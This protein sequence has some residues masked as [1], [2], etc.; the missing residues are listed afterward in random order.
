MIPL[1]SR[2]NLFILAVLLPL[3]V[4]SQ[5]LRQSFSLNWKEKEWVHP[6]DPSLKMI[7]FESAVHSPLRDYAPV[8][9]KVIDLPAGTT[10]CKVTVENLLLE[11][12][13]DEGLPL[14]VA[15]NVPADSVELTWNIGIARGQYQLDVEILPLLRAADGKLSRIVRFDLVIEPLGS[16]PQLKMAGFV[17]ESVLS[18]GNWYKLRIKKSGVCKVTY[19]DMQSMGIDMSTVTPSRIRLFGKPGGMLPEN[20]SFFRYDDLPE[21]AIQV[22][23]AAEG[24]FA[25]GDYFLFYAGSPD[26]TIFNTT[27][28]RFEHRQ[29][30]YSE[31]TYYFLNVDGGD[32]KRISVQ[33]QSA[34]APQHACSTFIDFSWYEKDIY[35]LIKSGK[36]WIGDRLDFNNPLFNLPEISFQ[37][38]ETSRQAW[39]RYRLVS[40]ASASSNFSI[41]ANTTNLTSKN[42]AAYTVDTF[43]QE[44]VETKTFAPVEGSQQVSVR[45]NTPNSTALGYIDWIELSVPRKMIFTGGQMWFADPVTAVAGAVTEF[46]LASAPQQVKIWEV[47]SPVN[48]SLVETSRVAD[49]LKF[50][51]A[52]DTLRRFVAWDGSSFLSAEFVEK[53]ENQNLHGI[54]AAEMLIVTHPDFL[55]QAERLANHHRMVDGM[56]VVVATN[57]QIY[58]EFSSGAPD[59]SAI[60]DFARML[61][62]VEGTGKLRYL[63][64][65]GDGSYDYKEHLPN[66]TNYVLAF[67]TQESQN[68]VFSTASDDFFGLLDS[69][70]GHDAYGKLDIGIG[71]FPVDNVE[72]AKDM[73]D[74]CIF[75]ATGAPE[76]LGEWRN[77]LCF[78]ADDED[79]NTHIRQVEDQ[80]TPSIEKDY[81]VYNLNKIYLDA[82]T[83][84]ATPGGARYPEVNAR[85]N[86]TVQKGVLIMNY[87]GHGGETGWSE[88]AIL[89]LNDINS[90]TNYSRMPVFVTATCEFSRFDDPGRVSA[91]E[92]VFLSPAGG[93]VAL[94]TTTRLANAGNNVE[95]TVDLYDTLF[96]ITDGN[97]PR[98]GDVIAHAKNQNSGVGLIRNFMLIGDPAMHLAF[99]RYNVVTTRINGKTLDQDADTISAMTLVNLE[100]MIAD[101]QG[102]QV[103][104]F[105]G[106][107]DVKV[108]DKY[109]W[110]MTRGNDPTSYKRY[111]DVQENILYQGKA[112]VTNGAF[113]VSFMVPRDIDFSFGNGKISYYAYSESTDARGYNT[114]IIIGGA[115][116]DPITDTEGPEIM[117]YMN[118]E[119]F[120]NGG[121]TGEH[122]MLLAYLSDESGLNTVGNGI[123][124]DLVATLDGNS[125]GSIVLNEY[126]QSDL[127]SYR[128]G[129]VMYNFHNLPEGKHSLSLKAWDIFNNSSEVQIEFEVKAN[130]A[131]RIISVKAYPNPFR[132]QVELEVEHNLFNAAVD[133]SFDI[134]TINGTHLFG[135]APETY[136][137]QG[138]IAGIL[139]WDG[140]NNHGVPMQDGVYLIR[141]RASSGSSSHMKTIR[142]IRAAQ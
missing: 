46:K 111:F 21:N 88:E 12:V 80:V 11:P 112:T 140:R 121:I 132:D 3:M 99:P 137:S 24:V 109:R 72:Q 77:S 13:S 57:Q 41:V 131:I 87:T 89:S 102:Q 68:L 105:N 58:N 52:T 103:S 18:T 32:G 54:T 35:N 96:S 79:S 48:V 81:P 123:G 36:Q 116:D 4:S 110:M 118:D 67:Q 20:S 98:F 139:Q 69:N 115:S 38:V 114:D 44:A 97:M 108:Y 59:I 63:L 25:P 73:V 6:S 106:I 49:T 39:I 56:S 117:L 55:Q 64:L 127:D 129:K 29:H 136:Y 76:N 90:W 51:L 17:S 30:L 23:T 104:S 70:E 66:N 83:Q 7:T 62:Q 40:R 9:H 95:L 135:T 107:V 74:K 2:Y 138:Y 85:I 141:V 126:Y 100:G 33:E 133:L 47:T 78:I 22:V 125:S 84:V 122:P 34:V 130:Q 37:N 14:P 94:F 43:S 45:Y 16:S 91:G 61:Y 8:F 10:G 82:Y 19:A 93:G 28:K 1:K 113:T 5:Q 31:Y 86:E 42:L 15:G 134:F 92:Q 119:R 142:V 26:A 65:F 60:R 75:Y 124:H 27:T 120:V 50:V 53:V 101:Q 128:S 71:R